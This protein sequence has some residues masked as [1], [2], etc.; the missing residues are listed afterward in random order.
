MRRPAGHRPGRSPGYT[1]AEENLKDPAL[2]EPSTREMKKAG[3][4]IYPAG[5]VA[6]AKTQAPHSTGSQFFLVYKD[7]PLPPQYTPLGTIGA[8]GMKT[9]KKIAD[10]GV[11]GGGP[12][13]PPNATASSTRRRSPSPEPGAAFRTRGRRAKFRSRDTDSRAAV[14]LCWRCAGC[15]LPAAARHPDS[16]NRQSMDQAAGPGGARPCRDNCGRCT[17]AANRPRHHVEEAL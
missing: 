15:L 10:A 7:S 3:M 4:K 9:L 5:M 16:T 11:Q 14:R 6:M 2:K 17:R 8:E 13:G 1:L 12:D